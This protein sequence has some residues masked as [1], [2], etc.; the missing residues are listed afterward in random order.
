MPKKSEREL[1]A[2]LEARRRKLDD[3][4]ESARRALRGRYAGLV[5]ELEIERLTEREFRDI[6]AQAIRVGGPPA[7]A[8]LKAVP[9]QGA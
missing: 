8:A 3:E 7:I 9:A 6:L 2:D 4:V 1:L 5:P